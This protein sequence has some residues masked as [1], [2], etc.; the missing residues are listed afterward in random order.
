[1][2]SPERINVPP[3]KRRDVAQGFVID[4]TPVGPQLAND[5]A[6]LN[7]VPGDNGVVQNRQTTECMHLITEFAAPQ[8]AFFADSGETERY[9]GTKLNAIPG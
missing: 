2:V 8:H 7:H 3:K 9:S 1:M 4:L 6:D 5:L